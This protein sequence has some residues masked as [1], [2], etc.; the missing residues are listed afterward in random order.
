MLLWPRRGRKRPPD[1]D[2]HEPILARPASPLRKAISWTRRHPM[3]LA[4]AAT[5]VLIGLGIFTIK[6]VEENAFL[7][8]QQANPA[9]T[10]QPGVL[11]TE[12]KEWTS[13]S[14]L[15]SVVAMFTS[16]AIR[17]QFDRRLQD[18]FDPIKGM[19]PPAPLGWKSQLAAVLIG[20]A[21][22]C[23]GKIFLAKIIQAYV[24]EGAIRANYFLGVWIDIWLGVALLWLVVRDYQKTY[25]G[26]PSRELT[27]EQQSDIRQAALEYD[28][29]QAIRIYRRAVPDAGVVE[30][31]E[32][33]VKLI[34]EIQSKEPGRALIPVFSLVTLNWKLVAVAIILEAILYAVGIVIFPPMR[35]PGFIYLFV[36]S[37]A[38]GITIL[39]GARMK[40]F[41]IRTIAS[42]AGMLILALSTLLYPIGF[43]L[44]PDA[45][46][47]S[48]AQWAYLLGILSGI[49]LMM[50]AYTKNRRRGVR[51][52][53]TSS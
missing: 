3:T 36:A 45:I 46:L 31:R 2:N 43:L 37:M 26:M 21:S 47:S 14:L 10:R 40:G 24:W 25:Y 48:M 17:K 34:A 5:L 15:V 1:L 13:I 33:V 52:E 29:P 30:A 49:F 38:L 4:A 11:A 6:L 50:S 35:S 53:S 8:A 23:Y 32:Y 18:L 42:F 27:V 51:P 12:L 16:L 19:Q 44:F 20:L 7:R 41:K 39:I 28:I 22:V 9:L